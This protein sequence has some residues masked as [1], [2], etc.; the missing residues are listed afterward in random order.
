MTCLRCVTRHLCDKKLVV[1]SKRDFLQPGIFR[2]RNL[3]DGVR[4]W[5][6]AGSIARPP[7]R[8]LRCLVCRTV[9]LLNSQAFKQHV[10]SN[11]HRKRAATQKCSED[12]PACFAF[13]ED[14]PVESEGDDT[15]MSR[16]CD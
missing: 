12:D 8:P 2:K 1:G 10:S 4:S 13:A 6:S 3:G 14:A 5:A 16:I 7:G 9:L 11:K 15:C